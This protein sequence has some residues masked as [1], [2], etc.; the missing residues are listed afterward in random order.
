[1][2]RK[3]RGFMSDLLTRNE[4]VPT[5]PFVADGVTISLAPPMARYSLRAR[6]AQA[7]ETVLKVK[8]PKKIGA[9]EGCIACLG[10]DEWLLRAP[11]GTMIPMGHTLPVAITDIS[12]RSIC[13][14]VEGPKARDILT[15]GCP[16][17]LENF[18]IGRATRTI[19]ETVEII[20]IREAEDRF[21]VEV[22]R[23][24]GDWL[25]T[26]LIKTASH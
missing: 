1:M 15:S 10:P 14:V 26:A 17:D 25:W 24:F 7:L 2:I 8:L 23:S 12:D 22:W 5:T 6:Q 18:A 11:A 4:P 19:F 9:T 3:E 21:H 20:L 16:L 13:L